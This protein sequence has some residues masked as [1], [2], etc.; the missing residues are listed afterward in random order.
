M[1]ARTLRPRISICKSV[2]FILHKTNERNRIERISDGINPI[3]ILLEHGKAFYGIWFSSHKQS[4]WFRI[5]AMSLTDEEVLMDLTEINYAVAAE[6][7]IYSWCDVNDKDSVNTW[8]WCESRRLVNF[9]Q[10]SL[11]SAPSLAT[12]KIRNNI[13]LHT[14]SAPLDT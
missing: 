10:F 13:Y 9:L 8:I 6:W 4:L 1:C 2:L 11:N 7:E 3:D 14:G 5:N 12:T